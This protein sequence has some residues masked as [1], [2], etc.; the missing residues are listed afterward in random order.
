MYNRMIVVLSLAITVACTPL[1][2]EQTNGMVSQDPIEI[3]AAEVIALPDPDLEGAMTLEEA[4][5]KRRSVRSFKP[6]PLSEAEISQLLWATQGV[7]QADGKRTAPS[8]GATYPLEVY[9]VTA[10]GAYKYDPH[11]HQLSLHQAGDLRPALHE[12]ALRQDAVLEA[13]LVI[14]ITAVYSRTA[15]RYGAGRAQRY[16]HM[17][18]GHAA[19]NLH[20]QTVALGLGS[21]PVGAFHD[22]EVKAILELPTDE[23][24]LYLVPVGK[25]R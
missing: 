5:K 25:P 15:E 1:Y 16:V 13:P 18:V 24:P 10:E 9:A 17:E 19:Q 20:L 11:H 3:W 7:T 21:V 8:A 12:A 22:S 6:D 2:G 23:E 14:V 4:L